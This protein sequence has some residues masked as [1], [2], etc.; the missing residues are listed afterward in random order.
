MNTLTCIQQRR[1]VK[2]VIENEHGTITVWLKTEHSLDQI[3]DMLIAHF[4]I[5]ERLK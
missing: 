1:G 4:K 5:R 2:H 3:C